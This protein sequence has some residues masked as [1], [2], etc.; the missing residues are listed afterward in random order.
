MIPPEI[1]SGRRI[2]EPNNCTWLLCPSELCTANLVGRLS[3]FP[4]GVVKS[5][6]GVGMPVGNAV[7]GDG[8]NIAFVI[9]PVLAQH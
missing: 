7:D 8:A 1:L 9:E 4:F 2:I 6:A 5:E 3:F